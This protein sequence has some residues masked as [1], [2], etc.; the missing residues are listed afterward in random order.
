MKTIHLTLG[1]LMIFFILPTTTD[2]QGREGD[3]IY[4]DGG[5]AI[6]GYRL[7]LKKGSRWYHSEVMEPGYVHRIKLRFTNQYRSSSCGGSFPRQ[8]FKIQNIKLTAINGQFNWKAPGNKSQIQITLADQRPIEPGKYQWYTLGEFTW[9][10]TGVPAHK[11][12][13]ALQIS[14]THELVA[15]ETRASAD[16]IYPTSKW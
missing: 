16:L 5:L 3:V 9:D 7:E 12:E 15:R 6:T 14:T 1:I 2:A 10:G 8:A 11:P 4:Q 13:A